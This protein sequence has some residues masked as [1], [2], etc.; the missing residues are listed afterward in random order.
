MLGFLELRLGFFSSSD[1]SGNDREGVITWGLR[2]ADI[3]SPVDT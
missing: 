1:F 2:D 3:F